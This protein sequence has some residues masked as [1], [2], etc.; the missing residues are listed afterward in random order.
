MLD[1]A[2]IVRRSKQFQQAPVNAILPVSESENMEVPNDDA[3]ERL[4]WGHFDHRL[5]P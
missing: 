1:E 5:W 2:A 3:I 4:E